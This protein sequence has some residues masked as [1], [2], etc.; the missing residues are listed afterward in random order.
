MGI[1]LHTERL[2]AQNA[3]NSWYAENNPYEIAQN[4]LTRTA[5]VKTILKVSPTV[6]RVEWEERDSEKGFPVRAK[7]WTGIFTIGI[8][9]PTALKE[10]IKNPLGVYIIEY[11]ANPNIG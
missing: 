10:V 3:I 1:Q 8:T 7:R 4:K 2:D 6:W 5:E 9:P 11:S